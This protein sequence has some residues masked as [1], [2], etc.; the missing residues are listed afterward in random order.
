M[1][2]NQDTVFNFNSKLP[3]MSKIKNVKLINPQKS[4]TENKSQNASKQ[5]HLHNK[6]QKKKKKKKRCELEGCRKKLSLIELKCK[7]GKKFCRQHFQ[8]EKHNCTFD[9]KKHYKEN[10]IK[11][12]VLGGGQIDKVTERV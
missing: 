12:G 5:E 1:T 4:T 10:L 2:S 7:C 9:F 11:K 6:H 8:L 3:P